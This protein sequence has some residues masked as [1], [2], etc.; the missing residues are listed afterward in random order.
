MTAQEA[1]AM[2]IQYLEPLRKDYGVRLGSPP[3]SSAPSGKNWTQEFL[4]VCGKDCNVDF[5]AL[6]KSLAY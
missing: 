6:R 5:I 3:T 1:K 4:S 2:W